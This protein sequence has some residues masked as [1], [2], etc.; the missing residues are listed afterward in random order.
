MANE[1]YNSGLV[2][3]LDDLALMRKRFQQSSDAET[4]DRDSARDCIEFYFGEQWAADILHQRHDRPSFTLNKLP[5]IMRQILNEEL[6]NPPAIE[7]SPDG[8]GADEE[9]AEAQQGLARHVE[10]HS[11]AE[12]AYS[13]AF[14]YMVLGGFGSW[15]VVHDYLPRSFD[16]ELYIKPI[17]NPFSV[18]WDP[19]A[20]EP[21][22]S[23]A[24]FCFVVLDFGVDEFKAQ[25][26]NSD[27]VG[28]KNFEGIGNRAPGW[29]WRDGCR[30]VEY[31]YVETEDATLVRLT[32]GRIVYDDEIPK[33]ARIMTD[34]DGA[35]VERP[36]TRRRVYLAHSNG[37]EWLRKP[38]ALP[39]PQI[40]IVTVLGER[41]WI[42]SEGM[43][44]VKGA[45][46]DL[47][48]AQKMF[49]FNS[50][51]I[52][53]T[54]A[55][56]ARANW[57][58]TVEQI[59]PFMELW[60]SANTR[61]ISVLPYHNIPG[62]N[63]PVK[64]ASEP[65][66]QGM[67]AVRMQ[68]EQDLRSISGVYDAATAGGGLTQPESGKAVLARRWQTSTG[69]VHWTKHLAVG[70]KRTADILLDYFP[71][72]YD[73][74]RVMRILGKDRQQKQIMVHAGRPETVPPM[75]PD[76]VSDV[77]DLTAGRYSST[78][79]INKNYDTQ[80]QESVQLMLSLIEVNPALAPLLADL[81]IGEMDFPNKQA[82][83]DR[84]QRA[85]PPGL[86]DQ[87][88]P[89][90]PNTLAATNSQL[91]QQNQ[92]LMAQVQQLSQMIQTKSVEGQSR[93]RIE[94]M[95]LM[96]TQIS[97]AARL[98]QERVKAQA[99]ILTRAADQHFTAVHD[100]AMS[101]KE[102]LHDVMLAGHQRA[103]NPPAPPPPA[104]AEV[105]Q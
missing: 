35:P 37:V 59:E 71:H 47:V 40:P 88:N 15:R 44:R 11:N 97:S 28:M 101:T 12:F 91:M 25:Y 17:Y 92:K 99:G 34:E 100:H 70:V 42:E 6:Q 83:V 68:S 46:F 48:E 73:T 24:R 63:A 103:L 58:A 10:L 38:E 2:E 50:S 31:F 105:T 75:L 55:L 61:N 67:S 81:V 79:S 65:P 64:I 3:E 14:L 16:Q 69:N 98:E 18:Y 53:E 102:H 8:E 29:V 96:A 5:A 85:L 76:G 27:L 77:I 90:D 49:N 43:F 104:A 51:A 13:N 1:S 23:D 95:K 26:P 36:D 22:K 39:V 62:V 54:M 82:F 84:L 32:D 19:A 89:Q 57:L 66:I 9:T 7:V 72:I 78:V 21:D 93:E 52:A 94:K 30:V 56:G 41:L 80:Q 86:Q 87:K 45:V 33:G 20:I 74:G 4:R 60:R